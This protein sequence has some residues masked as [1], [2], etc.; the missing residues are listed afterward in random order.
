M[1]NQPINIEVVPE[2][3]S[4]D[5]TNL[6]TSIEQL[7]YSQVEMG[8][9]NKLPEEEQEKQKDEKLIKLKELKDKFGA[10]IRK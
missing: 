10:Q 3:P 6:N 8:D 7:F 5:L 1:E 9:F 2:Q 4:N